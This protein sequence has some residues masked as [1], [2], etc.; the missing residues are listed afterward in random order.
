MH[1]REVVDAGEPQ[2]EELVCPAIRLE[3][4]ERQSRVVVDTV[5]DH[6]HQ[7]N[8]QRLDLWLVVS[9]DLH[10]KREELRDVIIDVSAHIQHNDFSKLATT[11]TIDTSN[12]VVF[13]DGANHVDHSLKVSSVLHK[14]LGSVVDEVFQSRQHI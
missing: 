7:M 9:Q 5:D 3:Y 4:M 13:E 1:S 10:G 8:T 11:N 6:L 2:A 12:L 14:G